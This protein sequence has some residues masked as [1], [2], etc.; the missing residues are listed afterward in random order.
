VRDRSPRPEPSKTASR[1]HRSPSPVSRLGA[2]GTVTAEVA[3]LPVIP[4]H[5]PRS[6]FSSATSRT[7][8][9]GAGC[10]MWTAVIVNAVRAFPAARQHPCPC[11]THPVRSSFISGETVTS[12][13]HVFRAVGSHQWH[14]GAFVHFSGL[15]R[16]SS[17]SPRRIQLGAAT[18]SPY[19]IW[20]DRCTVR[21]RWCTLVATG[22]VRVVGCQRVHDRKLRV[23]CIKRVVIKQGAYRIRFLWV[24]N[25]CSLHHRRGLHIVS[26]K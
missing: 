16:L 13:I 21:K 2:D 22:P 24:W 17:L 6:E 20:S 5:G 11:C 7:P 4:Y 8:S 25:K 14:A 26:K 15:L 19:N 12:T 18:G 1:G 3:S 10:R 23:F 9:W